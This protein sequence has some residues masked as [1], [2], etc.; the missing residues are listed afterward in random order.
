MQKFGREI[1]VYDGKVRARIKLN[2]D[3]NVPS[4]MITVTKNIYSNP[5]YIRNSQSYPSTTN[6]ILK[7]LCKQEKI[8]IYVKISL[9]DMSDDRTWKI[10]S[11]KAGQPYPTFTKKKLT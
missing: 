8:T 7:G 5:D 1:K 2:I 9:R 10:K 11:S 3:C 6:V 4:T